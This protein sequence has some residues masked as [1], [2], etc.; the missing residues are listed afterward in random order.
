VL[1]REAREAVDIDMSL[2]ESGLAPPFHSFDQL[3]KL[4]LPL[5]V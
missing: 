4:G 1:R 5:L 2:F 3:D